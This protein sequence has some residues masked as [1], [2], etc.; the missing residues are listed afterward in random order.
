MSAQKALAQEDAREESRQTFQ[1]TSNARVEV[2][3][4]NGAVIIQTSDSDFVEVEI[5][6]QATRRK[7]LKYH[8]VNVEHAPEI[9]RASC[10]ERV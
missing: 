4:V 3:N 5:V 8:P 2:L 9:G 6:R 7:D 1:L 10:R